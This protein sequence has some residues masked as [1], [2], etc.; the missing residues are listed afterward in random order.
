MK[1]TLQ[2]LQALE[3]W[4]IVMAFA[5]MVIACFIQVVNRNIFR[6]PVS[7]FEEAAKYSMV[8]MVLL[9]TELGLRDGT[10]ISIQGVVDKLP[11]KARKIIR[12][13][14]RIIVIVFAAVMTK[15]GWAM[16]MKQAKIGQTSPGLGIPMYIPYFALVLGFGLITIVQSGYL[17]KQCLDFNKPEEK[18]E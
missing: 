3:K 18:E 11:L 15:S 9:G 12:V 6:I 7:G 10:Q 8:Y 2:F 14:A 16:V 4:I 1:K 13:L 17:I 5:I